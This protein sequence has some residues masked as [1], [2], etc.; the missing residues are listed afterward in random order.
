MHL[1]YCF[2]YRSKRYPAPAWQARSVGRYYRRIAFV[3]RA[4]AAGPGRPR[5]YGLGRLGGQGDSPLLEFACRPPRRLSERCGGAWRG[6]VWLSNGPATEEPFR[7]A[8]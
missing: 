3:E 6:R 8:V 2:A 4:L 7:W 5:K 1:P